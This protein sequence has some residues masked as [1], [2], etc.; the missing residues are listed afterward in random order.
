VRELVT[1]L[2]EFVH[3]KIKFICM[4]FPVDILRP[5][6]KMVA[7]VIGAMAEMERELIRERTPAGL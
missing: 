6:G 3:K 7:T 1:E 4:I 5:E 2:D